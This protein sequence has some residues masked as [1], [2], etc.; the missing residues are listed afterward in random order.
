MTSSL[1]MWLI[2]I[3]IVLLAAGFLLRRRLSRNAPA[4]R[5]EPNDPERAA[6]QLHADQI[7]ARRPPIDLPRHHAAP[8]PLNPA[9]ASG[10]RTAHSFWPKNFKETATS[11]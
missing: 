10:N 5:A 11:Q 1:M 8:A 2:P 9:S 6:F 4:D 3:E 7:P